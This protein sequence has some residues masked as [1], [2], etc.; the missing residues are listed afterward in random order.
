MTTFTCWRGR[1]A[2]VVFGL[3]AI[4]VIG[5]RD[6]DPPRTHYRD[7]GPEGTLLLPAGSPKYAITD[8]RTPTADWY[9][10]RD[11][12][13]EAEEPADAD[14]TGEGW[15]AEIEAE[16][17]ELVADYNALAADK[18]IEELLAYHSEEQQEELKP[19][20]EAGFTLAERL[21]QLAAAFEEKLPDHAERIASALAHLGDPGGKMLSVKSIT[22]VDDNEATAKLSGGTLGSTCRF[23]VSDDE[24]FIE[25]PGA[26][27]YAEMKSAADTTVTSCD[28]WL[29]ALSSGEASAEEVLA[30]LEAMA[31]TLGR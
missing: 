7:L 31:E 21:P 6:S 22:V 4:S 27:D 1:W 29:T 17:R 16:L 2:W 11:P 19:I 5:C 14:A 28:G 15:K 10:F 20:I 30:Q 26:V 9:P 25:V 13:E 3:I 23:V 18:D 24:W 12:A 8:P